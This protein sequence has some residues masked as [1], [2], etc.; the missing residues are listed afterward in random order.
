MNGSGMRN[1][2]KVAAFAGLAIALVGCDSVREA[3]GV[4]KEPPDEFAVVT[5]APLIM[6]PDY[7]L[8]PPK[9]GAAPMNQVS[10]TEDAA[11]TLYGED[12]AQIA[13]QMPND[14]SHAEKLLLANTG[15]AVADHDIRRQLTADARSM[16]ETNDTLENKLLF[17]TKDLNAGAPLDADA[18]KAKID[19]NKS[20]QQTNSPV[21]AQQTASD[22]KHDDSATI[23]KGGSD[24]NS[25]GWFGW[26]F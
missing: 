2:L 13:A 1:F 18:E 8:K 3:A 26:I 11:A 6:P 10:P 15:G 14:Y 7:N 20:A 5:K 23:Q 12:P 19:A 24:D 22:E 25:G 9:P 21:P 17:Q 4:T 16:E